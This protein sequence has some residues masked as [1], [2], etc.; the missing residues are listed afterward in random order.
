MAYSAC[1]LLLLAS[2][3][4]ITASLLQGCGFQLRGGVELA[5]QLQV[6]YLKSSNPY[7]GVTAAL[8]D[9][10]RAAG[11]RLVEDPGEATAI[12]VIH[13]ERSTRR[14]LSVGSTGRTSEYELFEEVTFSLSDSRGQTLLEAQTLRLTRDLVFDET[15]VL[16]KAA[17][18]EQTREQMRR[19]LARQILTRIDVGLRTQ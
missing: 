9:S 1:R 7:S 14:V 13:D 17:E 16:G 3:L 6:T 11:A 18:S 19:S 4:M 2:A 12:L 5:P 15:E 10:L 8:R